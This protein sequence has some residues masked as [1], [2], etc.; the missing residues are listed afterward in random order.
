MWAERAHPGVMLSRVSRSVRNCG[1]LGLALACGAMAHASEGAFLE[2][3]MS[4]DGITPTAADGLAHTAELAAA[5]LGAT[6]SQQGEAQYAVPI[7]L[8]SARLSPEVGLSYSSLAG[9]HSGVGRGWSLGGGMTLSRVTGQVRAQAY[10]EE[11]TA[12]LRIDGG[13]VSGILFDRAD[14]WAL[15]SLAPAPVTVTHDPHSGEFTVQSQG[16]TTVLAPMAPLS[17]PDTWRARAVVDAFGNQVVYTWGADGLLEAVEWGGVATE[18]PGEWADAPL[19]T[20]EVHTEDA[21]WAS[22]QGRA[23][24]LV[25]LDR[26]VI[27]LSLNLEVACIAGAECADDMP[28]PAWDLCYAPLPGGAGEE[29]LAS[30]Y[31]RAEGAESGCTAGESETAQRLA[32]FDYTAWNPDLGGIT[33]AAG[34]GTFGDG[35][36]SKHGVSLTSIDLADVNG[37]GWADRLDWSGYD[38]VAQAYLSGGG[39][40]TWQAPEEADPVETSGLAPSRGIGGSVAAI[41]DFDTL[42]DSAVRYHPYYTRYTTD[43]WVDLDHDGFVDLVRAPYAPTS[44]E[45][46]SDP[47]KDRVFDDNLGRYGRVGGSPSYHWEVSFGAP[48]GLLPPVALVAPVRFPEVS[49]S[50]SHPPGFVVEESELAQSFFDLDTR[51]VDLL[52]LTADGWAD[53]VYAAGD[54]LHVYPYLPAEG[55]WALEPITLAVPGIAV[56]ALEQVTHHT[57]IDGRFEATDALRT[58]QT[59]RVEYAEVTRRLVDLNGDGFVDVVDTSNWVHTGMWQVAL[60]HGAGFA[61]D[62]VPWPA[63]MG[64]VSETFEGEP[65]VHTCSGPPIVSEFGW[66]TFDAPVLVEPTE[67]DGLDPEDGGPGEGDFG[68]EPSEGDT[69]EEFGRIDTGGSPSPDDEP[70]DDGGGGGD[71]D[72]GPPP[73]AEYS[74]AWFDPATAPMWD[75]LQGMVAVCGFAT[76]PDP[77]RVLVDLLDLDGDGRPDLVD[78]ESS[79][80]YRNLGARFDLEGAPI[81]WAGFPAEMARSELRT[82]AVFAP[83]REDPMALQPGGH[84]PSTSTTLLQVRDV[85][86]DGLPDVVT[87]EAVQLAPFQAVGALERITWST[88]AVTEL[89]Y[90]T[91]AAD[92]GEVDPEPF[93]AHRAV[94][95]RIGLYDPV[96][97]QSAEHRLSYAG[98][99]QVDGQFQG[100]ALHTTLERIADVRTR[101]TL[102][103]GAWTTLWKRETEL[104]LERDLTTVTEER[105]WVDRALPWLPADGADPSTPMGGEVD[106]QIASIHVPV[107]EEWEGG[108]RLDRREVQVFGDDGIGVWS[109]TDATWSAEGDLVEIARGPGRG[110]VSP[111][112]ESVRAL[113]EDWVGDD[114]LRLPATTRTIGWSS[115][116]DAEVEQEWIRLVY[117]DGTDEPTHGGLPSTPALVRQEVCG[118][119]VGA[120]DCDT[121][122]ETWTWTRGPR[123]EVDEFE[124]PGGG[125]GSTLWT[126]GATVASES[127]NELFH[128]TQQTVDALGRPLTTTD[129]NGVITRTGYD[130][131]GRPGWTSVQGVGDEPRKVRRWVHHHE[132]MPEWVEETR[133][134]W[135]AP[136]GAK[137]S[138]TAYEVRD[139]LGRTV[140]TWSPEAGPSGWTV[141]ETLTDLSGAAAVVRAPRG[142]GAFDPSGPSL[143]TPTA[144][145]ARAYT[146][147]MGTPRLGWSQAA[148][149]TRTS[150]P[151]PRVTLVEDGAG[152]QRRTTTDSLG[153]LETVEEGGPVGWMRTGSYSWD[154]RGRVTQH[155][156]ANGNIYRYA[157]DRAGRLR[158]VDR[159]P[160]GE[161]A[162]WEPWAEYAY[163]GP[164]PISLTD[165]TGSVAVVW[166]HDAIGRLVAQTVHR[167]DGDQTTDIVFDDDVWIGAQTRVSDPVHTREFSYDTGETW[168]LGHPTGTTITWADGHL[169]TWASETDSDGQVVHAEHPDGVIVDTT[170]TPTRWRDQ[171]AVHV[172]DDAITVVYTPGDFGRPLGGWSV[173]RP[174][175]NCPLSVQRVWSGPDTLDAINVERSDCGP[176]SIAYGWDDSGRLNS[177]EYT[178]AGSPAGLFTYG[179]DS[180]G[181][182]NEV[183]RDAALVEAIDRDPLGLPLSLTRETPHVDP[184]LPAPLPSTWAYAPA[185][186]FGEVPSRSG[187]SDD[188]PWMEEVLSWDAMG[189]LE[190]VSHREP[191]ER[192]FEHYAY[193]GLGRLAQIDGFERTV[194]PDSGDVTKLRWTHVHAHGLDDAL[195]FESRTGLAPKEVHRF[196]SYLSDTSTGVTISPLPMVRVVNGD[197]RFTVLEPGGNAAWVF[198]GDGAELSHASLGGTGVPVHQSGDPWH[199]DGLHGAEPERVSGLLHHGIRHARLDDGLW[200][201]PEPLLLLGP[202]SGDLTRPLGFGPAYAAGD[203]LLWADRSGFEPEEAPFKAIRALGVDN[204]AR[205]NHFVAMSRGDAGKSFAEA[206]EEVTPTPQEIGEYIMSIPQVGKGMGVLAAGMDFMADG[207]RGVVSGVVYAAAP[208]GRVASKGALS[209]ID[210]FVDLTQHRSAH[211]LNRHRAGAGKAGKT[212]FPGSWS[213]DRILH[214]VSDIATDP[215]AATGVGKWNS[216]YAISVRDGIEIRVDFYP[217]T[218]PQYAGQI[219]TAYPINVT[220]NP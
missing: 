207:V 167:P 202:A 1:V 6:A 58:Y 101:W 136:G 20:L 93:A 75:A 77:R 81:P 138:R 192:Q 205:T 134:T 174:L 100:F 94:V 143:A 49:A 179:Y 108:K 5:D 51:V 18:V 55:G 125:G 119:P 135:E 147:A 116:L 195:V 10:G 98:P 57:V 122:W 148:G 85:N 165:A 132:A 25:T 176:N 217:P 99:S 106:L 166:T 206:V 87:P 178:G 66:P 173:H 39:A 14:G 31:L 83:V 158:A 42:I 216:P 188:A 69:A 186:R 97:D 113:F 52:D 200:L 23:G 54:G 7:G 164:H 37:D 124:A 201:Q 212:E 110:S 90:R 32:A 33:D 12:P 157:F 189:R 28:V 107:Y 181:R 187:A 194:D 145:D 130:A 117:D 43:R 46:A 213:D 89:E 182:L 133:N 63:P 19:Y 209:K 22:Y 50:P 184:L 9:P 60:G 199:L 53:V 153:R 104:A 111:G 8:P 152:R 118:A 78:A 16:I 79:V 29:V 162:P 105:L 114:T 154:G 121:E 196:G 190:Q 102:G 149:T 38:P 140:Q 112:P 211:I 218:H 171:D 47:D 215:T 168:G 3:S 198:D 160:A 95:S 185:E 208:V 159:R 17:D 141:A 210:D 61:D 40:P 144:W 129:A 62:L 76:E 34:P 92:G 204:K 151:M 197:L 103:E 191:D 128:T 155:V 137:L 131:L 24:G 80:W 2:L 183:W 91:T 169:A 4:G 180:L 74:D 26:R 44:L 35:E 193:D 156:D 70:V 71:F 59:P 120:A 219:S 11:A 72:D 27:A 115:A 82:T 203:T 139:G 96:T 126:L 84:N 56:H 214:Q 30:V 172:G 15:H 123:G 48:W 150:R 41:T 88:G 67:G 68:H 86:A 177:R 146:D 175:W 13:G 36:T 65:G 127:S 161:D 45:Y 142:E 21:P 163:A 64:F 109:T 73:G 220:P 170:F